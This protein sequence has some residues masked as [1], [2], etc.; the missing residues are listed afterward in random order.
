MNLL[1]K[2]STPRPFFDSGAECL[3]DSRTIRTVL[4][5][6]GKRIRDRAMM[7]FFFRPAAL[8]PNERVIRPVNQDTGIPSEAADSN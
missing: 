5:G 3:N 4:D 2:P 1:S 7:S 6:Q 8:R